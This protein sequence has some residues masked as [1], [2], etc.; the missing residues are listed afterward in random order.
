MPGRTKCNIV[1][2]VLN[3]LCSMTLL[4]LLKFRIRWK[5]PSDFSRTNMDEIN[6]L[7]ACFVSTITDLANKVLIS[8]VINSCPFLLNG[9]WY[10]FTAGRLSVISIC[11][12]DAVVR[13]SGSNVSSSYCFRRNLGISPWN[14][15]TLFWRYFFNEVKVFYLQCIL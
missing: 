13:S 9:Y 6:S 2:I 1:V 4:S 8:S 10:N 15:L 11:V 3:F 7:G 5:L 14:D 12:P